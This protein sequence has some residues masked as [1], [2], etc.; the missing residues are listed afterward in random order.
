M[1]I[2]VYIWLR[3]LLLKEPKTF[4]EFFY[5]EIANFIAIQ[6]K[7]QFFENF[8]NSTAERYRDLQDCKSKNEVNEWV[9][10]IV[11]YIIKNIE[12]DNLIDNYFAK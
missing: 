7:E 5:S 2:D 3:E 6:N 1:N 10:K 9:D 12:I 8:N 11:R 4:N